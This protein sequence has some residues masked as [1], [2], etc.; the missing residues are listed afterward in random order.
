MSMVEQSAFFAIVLT[1]GSYEIGRLI[2]QKTKSVIANPLLIS[3]IIVVIVL[4]VMN[5]DGAKYQENVSFISFFLTPATVCL[6][7]PLY[8]QVQILR[9]SLAGIL[10]GILAGTFTSVAVVYV[11]CKMFSMSDTMTI[12]LLPKSITTAMG[13]VL[14]EQAGGFAALT[15]IVIAVTGILGNMF[16]E[17]LA[18]IFHITDPIAK[19]VAYGTAAHVMG[20]SKAAEL[21]ELM[22]AVSSLSLV[23]A[24][25][26]TAVIFCFV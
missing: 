3:I 16:G 13:M 2:Q 22:G 18:K 25:I 11:M 7:I 23:V 1:L 12:S 8:R 5:I 14:S 17:M 6:A 15:A 19:G 4:K 24:G 10:V 21:D 20:T 9:K 26:V